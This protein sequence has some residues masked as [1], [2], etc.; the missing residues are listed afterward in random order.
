MHF[1]QLADSQACFYCR[2]IEKYEDNYPIREGVFTAENLIFRCSWHS[3]FLCSDC[4]K[5]QHFSWLYFCPSSGKTI[6]GSCDKPTLKPIRFWN[7]SYAYDFWCSECEISHYDLLFTEYIGKHPWQLEQGE[8]TSNLE[9][10]NPSQP[11]WTPLYSRKGKEIS[12]QEALETEDNIT[13]IRKMKEGLV[14]HTDL[15]PEDAVKHQD[16]QERWEKDSG[17]WIDLYQQQT[18]AD[19]GDLNRQL[20]IDPA[21]WKL[22][23]DVRKL[24]VLDAGCGNGY[25][26]RE[27]AR[28]GA[29]VVGVDFSKT[30]I[31]HCLKMEENE[32]LGCKFIHAS[33]LELKEIKSNKFDLV[34]SNVVMVDVPNYRQAF[35]EI[36]RVLKPGGRFI[37]SNLHPVFGRLCS[38]DLKLP[39][40]S[41]RNEENVYKITD[42]YFKSGAILI[43]WRNLEPLWSFERTLSEYSRALK[44]AGFVIQEI[45]EPKPTIEDIQQNPRFLAFDADR[46]P[47]FIIYDCLKN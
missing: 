40:D 28:R 7:K 15:I 17:I 22:F 2:E 30:F 29:A 13:P 46:F 25:L 23:G 21:L 33:L 16:T 4:G 11:I 45:V 9:L 47:L 27:L 35:K 14:F 18:D 1:Y 42:R 5:Y 24:K 6:C 34:V 32:K 20:V 38:V 3:K 41:P 36:S 39:I 26:T 10:S 12:L 43:S 37:W 19:E 31:K 44:D 8:I